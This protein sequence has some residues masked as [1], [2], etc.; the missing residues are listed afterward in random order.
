[1]FN[2]KRYEQYINR[3]KD[4]KMFLFSLEFYDMQF[5][6]RERFKFLNPEE[7]RRINNEN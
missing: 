5:L 2:Q 3:I 1:M 4:K 6:K 7:Y